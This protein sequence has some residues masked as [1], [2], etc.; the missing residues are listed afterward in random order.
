MTLRFAAAVAAMACS[1]P[2]MAAEMPVYQAVRAEKIRPRDG[3]GHVMA[4]IQ[5]GQEVTV[6]YLGGSITAANGWRPK[7]TAWLQK[8]FPKAKF[9]EIHASIGGT[10]SN[11]GVFRLEHDAL[12]H[13]PDL[14]FV[15][16]AVNDGGAAPENIWR[17]MEGIVRQ[18]WRKNPCTD[19]VFAY[20]IHHGM[21]D[22]LKKGDCPRSA[23]AMEMLAD[24]YGIPS[25]NF[26]VPVVELLGQDKLVFRA[27]NQPERGKIWFTK[28][29]CHPRDEGHEIYLQLMA[30]AITQMKGSKPADHRAKLAKTF[31][32]DNWEAA[33]MVPI[34]QKML[35]GDWK[36]LPAD[37]SKQKSF[38][39]RMGQLWKAS[40]P[41]AKLHFKFRGSTAMLYDL[42][43]PDCG[44]VVIT[45]DGKTREKPAP[46]FDS[47]CTYHR[48]ATLGLVSGSD[49]NQIHEVTIEIHPQQPDRKSVA[50]RLKDPD[51]ELKMPK[52]QGT[53]VW[54]SQILLLGDLVE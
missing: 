4:R 14:L 43:G 39:K 34:N 6:A 29:G 42:L 38:G 44:Q 31:V 51:K 28:D 11:L 35:S 46:L 13:N 22:D 37:D 10:G 19:I 53:N 20:T 47:Y 40:Q 45:V 5:A 12:Q 32:A 30:E 2:L 16:F 27:D 9:N 17:S 33:K 24:F 15:E 48:I 36:A 18:T 49:P 54:A 7:T 1:W 41:G 21:L 50:F 25:V 26:A 23:S 3:I 52:F 8:T